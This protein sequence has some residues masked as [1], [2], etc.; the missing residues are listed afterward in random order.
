MV[1]NNRLLLLSLTLLCCSLAP[2]QVNPENR[3]LVIN[4]KAGDA[5][6]VEI[7]SRTY[8]DLETLVRIANGS[9]GF[10]GQKITLVLRGSEASTQASSPESAQ[11]AS[12]NAL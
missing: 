5:T 10:E 2:A 3:H 6:V 11:P 9:L 1:S 8:I 4:G 7:N 12:S